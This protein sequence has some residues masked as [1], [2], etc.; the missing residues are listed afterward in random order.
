MA[1]GFMINGGGS[2]GN[3][4][5]KPARGATT[6]ALA[7]NT[8]DNGTSGVGATLT[9]N[10]NGALGAIDGLTYVVGERILVKNEVATANNGIYTVTVVGTAGT[11]Y[12][13]TRATDFDSTSEIVAG[14]VVSIAEG[15]VNADTVYL[16]TANN[17]I[18]VGT[19]SLTF[20]AY[21]AGMSIGSSISGAT[22]TR[23]LFVGAGPVLADDAGLT[24]NSGTDTLTALGALIAG[25]TITTGTAAGTTGKVTFNGTTSGVVGLTV[26]A[27]AGTY[28]FTLPT[29]GGTNTY[30]LQTN[31]SGTTTWAAG[32]AGDVVGPVSATDNAIVRFDATTGKLVQ[33]SAVTIADTTGNMAGVGTVNTH[34]I[35]GGTSTFAILTNK[36][37]VFAATTSAELAGVISDETG[38]SGGGVL[39]FNNGPTLTAPILNGEKVALVTKVFSDS[40]Y[41]ALSTDVVILCDCTSG[42]MTVNLPAVA[43]AGLGRRYV[44]KK[45]D[46]SGNAVTID[47]NASDTIDGATTKSLATQYASATLLNSTTAWY[48]E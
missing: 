38:S 21:G 45:I 36:L 16:L 12:V 42:A 4:L 27:A 28:T 11:K 14:S 24:Y 18:T 47:G 46:S 26:A 40:P 10:A 2:S 31:G 17:P 6:A 23:V 5:F 33:D 20:S 43:S 41:T 25:T 35:P 7:A 44:I 37:S 1:L 19:T 34:T 13:L 30:F 9:A 39:V 3:V 32:N 22:A 15:T 48:I 8:Y 29:T